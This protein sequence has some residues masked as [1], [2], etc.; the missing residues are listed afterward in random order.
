AN[1]RAGGRLVTGSQQGGQRAAK[2]KRGVRAWAGPGP[3]PLPAE[4]PPPRIRFP[5]P[6]HLRPPLLALD[7]VSTGYVPGAP[8]L[9]RID[10]RIDPDDR[11]ALLGPNGNGKT[12]LA[13]LLAG[14]PAPFSGEIT[15]PP[16]LACGFF[17]QHQIDEMRPEA[18]PFDHLAELMADA[19]PEA[20][21]ARLGSFGFGQEKAFLPV[22]DLSGGE[23]ARLNLALVT[24]RA[25]ALLILD[26]P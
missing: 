12:T 23:R 18:S 25:P 17:A 24:Y 10:L 15:R 21:R 13:R 1:G 2:A 11:I 22:A 26:E 3:I 19:M 6:L 16:K 5:D 14:R 7:R 8:V 20:I 9:S 4:G